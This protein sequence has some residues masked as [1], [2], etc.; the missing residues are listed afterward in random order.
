MGALSKFLEG[1]IQGDC[2]IKGGPALTAIQARSENK[3]SCLINQVIMTA[4][5]K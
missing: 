4:N 3:I 5:W 2:I 1:C